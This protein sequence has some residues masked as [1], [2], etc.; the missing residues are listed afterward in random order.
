MRQL[1]NTI[2]KKEELE[3]IKNRQFLLKRQSDQLRLLEPLKNKIDNTL[4]DK[5]ISGLVKIKKEEVFNTFACRT[6]DP[7]FR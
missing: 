7:K 5:N 6:L 4:L 3:L 2:L 1:L